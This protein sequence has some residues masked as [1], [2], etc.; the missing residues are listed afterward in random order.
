MDS[1]AMMAER[2]AKIGGGGGGGGSGHHTVLENQISD[3]GP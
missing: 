2:G 1:A 3:P